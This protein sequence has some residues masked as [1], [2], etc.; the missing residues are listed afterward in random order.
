VGGCH[1]VYATIRA[2]RFPGGAAELERGGQTYRWPR[3]TFE[4]RDI[5]YVIDFM[6]PRFADLPLRNKLTTVFHELYHISPRCDGDLRRF[7]GKN[8]AHGSS[9]E[10]YNARLQPWIDDYLNG[11]SAARVTEFLDLS[12][13]DL[14]ARHTRVVGRKIQPIRPVRVR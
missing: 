5:L 6:M 4:G 9:R 13:A 12:F 2:L 10:A 14:Q 7:P 8:Y 1:G 11:D 3:L